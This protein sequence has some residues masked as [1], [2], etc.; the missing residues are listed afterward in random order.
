MW[1]YG[2]VHIHYGVLRSISPFSLPLISTILRVKLK[3][4][5]VDLRA[6]Y[7]SQEKL[8]V[9]LSVRLED[10]SAPSLELEGREGPSRCL[11]PRTGLSCWTQWS[12]KERAKMDSLRAMLPESG[13]S[14]GIHGM[15]VDI[16][17]LRHER[18]AVAVVS[19]LGSVLLNTVVVQGRADGVRLVARVRAAGFRRRIRCDILDEIQPAQA[20]ARHEKGDRVLLVLP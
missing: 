5:T 10:A 19:A 9:G 14:E 17:V 15:L 3:E 8:V 18:S 6:A 20:V 13:R 1:S 4:E 11:A 16:L 7:R 2:P 12:R